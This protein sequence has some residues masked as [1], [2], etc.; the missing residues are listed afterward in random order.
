[1][2][3]GRRQCGVLE[4]GSADVGLNALATPFRFGV[5]RQGVHLAVRE[6]VREHVRAM[7]ADLPGLGLDD[8]PETRGESG[9]FRSMA[10]D[11]VVES[12]VR[13]RRLEKRQRTEVPPHDLVVRVDA[14]DLEQPAEMVADARRGD[15]VQ[16]VF[17]RSTPRTVE[18][19]PP[20]HAGSTHRLSDP[21]PE[22]RGRRGRDGVER[23]H[24][25]R[26]GGH[27]IAQQGFLVRRG[28]RR[29]EIERADEETEALVADVPQVEEA[30]GAVRC[31]VLVRDGQIP[32]IR[33]PGDR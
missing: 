30:T 7:R 28:R 31:E 6:D 27:P 26:V 10:L 8:A 25:V 3:A 15:V 20:V 21:R 16:Q 1:M 13:D 12:C 33:G 24:V 5:L 19:A 18:P 22:D 29:G 2:R 14:T 11:P 9:P 23:G 17:R 32:P 4:T